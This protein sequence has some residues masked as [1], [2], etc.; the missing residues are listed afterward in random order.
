M[1][2]SE[3]SAKAHMI[4]LYVE[5]NY[6]SLEKFRTILKNHRV[7]ASTK[8]IS[9][10]MKLFPVRELHAPS[11][12]AVD[13]QQYITSLYPFEMI[14]IDLLDYSKYSTRNR[15][16]KYLLIGVDIFS[17]KAF[18]QPIKEKTPQQVKRAFETFSIIPTSVY[19]DSGNEFKGEFLKYLDDNDIINMSARLGT[20]HSLGVVDKFSRTIKTMISK[21]MT[22]NN[23][24]N[25][26]DALD[27]LIDIYNRTP[28]S[29]LLDYTPNE[30][31]GDLTIRNKIQKMNFEKIKFNNELVAENQSK[32]SI[33]DEVR[34][35]LKKKIFQKGYEQTYSTQ[36]YP[37]VGFDGNN[38]IIKDDERKRNIPF[39]D[40]KQSFAK[41]VDSN[42]DK[43][44]L[45]NLAR[46]RA[47]LAREG[48]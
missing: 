40:V 19:H 48:I 33:G 43:K 22:A 16:Y 14:Q 11:Y 20:H 6:P 13:K 23:T 29:S 5:F 9:E 10:V 25:Y 42:K 26:I 27:A 32:L 17:R 39:H 18:A 2:F 38:V 44:T 21:F 30:V 31:L 47:R 1:D 7:K 24:A 37:I 3:G 46:S 15:N 12:D 41:S 4:E 8:E 34:L 28:H 45:D 35:K 36:T